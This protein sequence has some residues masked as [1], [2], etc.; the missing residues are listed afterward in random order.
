MGERVCREERAG[1][2][3]IE[4]EKRETLKDTEGREGKGRDCLFASKTQNSRSLV[5]TVPL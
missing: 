1:S 4:R 2:V 3:V 5:A